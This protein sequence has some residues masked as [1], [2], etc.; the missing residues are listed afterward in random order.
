MI[1]VKLI[2]AIIALLFVAWLIGGLTRD[3][4]RRRRRRRTFR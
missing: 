3:R 4:T 1:L 2:V